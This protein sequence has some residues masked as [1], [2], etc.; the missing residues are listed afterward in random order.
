MCYRKSLTKF[1]FQFSRAVAKKMSFEVI[2]PMTCFDAKTLIHPRNHFVFERLKFSEL[3]KLLFEYRFVE[4]MCV[5]LVL[6]MYGIKGL[7]AAINIFFYYSKILVGTS[8]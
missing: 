6:V 5:F 1:P 8:S 3:S 2:A 7:C 4:E